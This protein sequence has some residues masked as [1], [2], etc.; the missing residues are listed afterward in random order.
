[1]PRP[2]PRKY[3]VA[4]LSSQLYPSTD[5]VIWGCFLQRLTW[6]LTAADSET[7]FSAIHRTRGEGGLAFLPDL[8]G[9]IK[10]ISSAPLYEKQSA[11]IFTGDYGGKLVRFC[12]IN[13][14]LL[15]VIIGC[16]K[17]S[18]SPCVSCRSHGEAASRKFVIYPS[19]IN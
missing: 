14:M 1:L 2:Q 19:G 16:T 4:L 6:L 17:G 8:S 3:L 15:T 5:M 13:W 18:E 12:L 9:M 7:S 11:S 10:N